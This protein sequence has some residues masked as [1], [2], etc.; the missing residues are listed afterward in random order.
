MTSRAGDVALRAA[1]GAARRMLLAAARYIVLLAPQSHACC[2]SKVAVAPQ[3]AP[4]ICYHLAVRRACLALNCAYNTGRFLHSYRILIN[5]TSVRDVNLMKMY[6]YIIPGL[7][8][9]VSTE[10]P[11][12]MRV[13]SSLHFLLVDLLSDLLAVWSREWALFSLEV[14]TQGCGKTARLRQLM[15]HSVF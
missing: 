2:T 9:I 7:Y 5:E 14:S 15:S 4:A 10:T 11:Q 8:S 3:A 12:L 1:I 6:I 13:L